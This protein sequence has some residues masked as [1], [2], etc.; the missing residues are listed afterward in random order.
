MGSELSHLLE[1]E[2]RTEI[3]AV[4]GEARARAEEIVAAARPEAEEILAAARQRAE[5]ARV[6]ART[7]ASSTAHLRAAA[8]ILGA[9]DEAIRKVFE[10]AEAA[11]RS[12]MGNPGRR[13][14][15]VRAF[16]RE[17]AEGLSAEGRVTVEVPRGDAQAARE[18]CKELRLD[19]DVRESA[20]VTDG[21]L[22]TSPDGRLAVE[23]TVPSRL[24][25]ARLELVS[26]V[27]ETLW[28]T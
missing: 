4:Q 23:N 10:G 2:A 18:A 20:E 9:K 24:A 13:R 8:L 22:L 11:L 26:R 6:Q 7:Q 12:A 17:A 3:E 21:V 25:R 14:E 16:L 15:M 27:A 19:A 1:K 5:S 28:G